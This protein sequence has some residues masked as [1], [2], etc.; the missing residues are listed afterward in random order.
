MQRVSRKVLLVATATLV[1][2]SFAA[3]AGA[4]SGKGEGKKPIGTIASFDGTTLTVDLASGETETATVTEDT[5]IKVEHRGH[6][7]ARG[8]GHGS[9]S[10]G[11]SE[12]LTAGAFVLRM[13]VDEDGS[14]DKIRVRPASLHEVEP[15]PTPTAVETAAPTA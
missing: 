7:A 2:A 1:V 5:Q 3:S 10:H 6:H 13:K 14:L 15:A 4:H 11:D 9:P 8:K 12:A